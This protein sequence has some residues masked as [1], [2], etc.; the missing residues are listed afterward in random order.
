MR[1]NMKIFPSMKGVDNMG[2]FLRWFQK[3]PYSN[4][5]KQISSW[6]PLS[7]PLTVEESNLVQVIKKKTDSHNQNNITRT[8]AYLDMFKKHPELHWALLAHMV[9]RNA[10]WNM[11]DLKG[12]WISR[13]LTQKERE[14]Y[15]LFMER[16]NWLIFQD[17]Y[18]Q[19]LL[20]EEVKKRNM[21]LFYLL[22]HFGVSCFMEVM[23]NDFWIH[24]DVQRLTVSLIINEQNYIEKRVVDKDKFAAPVLKDVKYFLQDA[25]DMCMI[26]FPCASSSGYIHYYGK[27]VNAFPILER[28]IELGK[29]L[30]SLLFDKEVIDGV[31]AW[32]KNT[33]HT[34][35]RENYWPGLFKSVREEAPL[36]KY[37]P[38]L[39][40]CVLKPGEPRIYSPQL[41]HVW[42]N[43]SHQPALVDD[44]CEDFTVVEQLEV[45]KE[46]AVRAEREYCSVLEKVESA[47]LAKELVTDK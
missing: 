13:L 21:N 27:Q 30:Y 19:L 1:Y 38:R 24:R 11:T 45:K 22:S 14:Q 12:E 5:K 40:N 8:M 7:R 4:L 29:S 25:L 15:F 20:Y 16:A 17:A 35:S 28:R 42:P 37:K 18:P 31:L 46:K 3:S 10:G 6:E 23:W 34:G 33:Y 47:I 26:L 32:C 39:Q 9:S 44:W 2:W 43:Q 41:T 36:K